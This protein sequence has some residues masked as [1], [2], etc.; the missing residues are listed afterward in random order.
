MF[1]LCVTIEKKT[2]QFVIK[3][4]DLAM[5][6]ELTKSFKPFDLREL[7]FQMPLFQEAIRHSLM[8]LPF[9]KP[10]QMNLNLI[11]DIKDNL[12]RRFKGLTFDL[13][14]SPSDRIDI[15]FCKYNLTY[16]HNDL[17]SLTFSL[18]QATD[19]QHLQ[20]ISLTANYLL[21]IDLETPKNN[22]VESVRLSLPAITSSSEAFSDF[23]AKVVTEL[24][25]KNQLNDIDDIVSSIKRYF[26]KLYKNISIKET[27][28]ESSDP[29]FVNKFFSISY[30]FTNLDLYIGTSKSERHSTKFSISVDY[31]KSN[32]AGSLVNFS[33]LRTSEELLKGLL[34]Q[35]KAN[36]I[37]KPI[38]DEIMEMFALSLKS[39]N[40]VYVMELQKKDFGELKPFTSSPM[41]GSNSSGVKNKEFSC[42]YFID[43]EKRP[44]GHVYLTSKTTEFNYTFSFYMD[45]F[46]RK[47]VNNLMTNFF[48]GILESANW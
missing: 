13:T 2:K 12:T 20:E 10:H 15:S 5:K 41:F 30:E 34:D 19:S 24:D 25:F 39:F 14:D 43:S 6:K 35:A 47:L 36:S 26:E 38:K 22:S 28:T 40:D 7:I 32:S 9:W 33:T 3:I 48:Y 23:V 27:K 45:K 21:H 44:K 16:N 1:S 11:S 31:P 18:E 8:Y 29:S 37:L 46:N 4:V 17:G 42:G